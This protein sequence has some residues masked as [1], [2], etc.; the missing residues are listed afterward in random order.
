MCSQKWYIRLS[1]KENYEARNTLENFVCRQCCPWKQRYD[2]WFK[3]VELRQHR[4][5]QPS[6]KSVYNTGF[7]MHTLIYVQCFMSV[8]YYYANSSSS[9]NAL[10][11]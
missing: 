8:W 1:I 10:M 4:E 3:V 6:K 5:K 7:V 9:H 11:L 2:K